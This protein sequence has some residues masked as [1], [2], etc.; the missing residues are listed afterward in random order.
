MNVD[1]PFCP[2]LH[3][4]YEPILTEPPIGD[5]EDGMILYGIEFDAVDPTPGALHGVVWVSFKG[6]TL[7]LG[8]L[9]H[10]RPGSM[11]SHALLSPDAPMEYTKTAVVKVGRG[12]FTLPPGTGFTVWAPKGQIAR[13]ILC[14]A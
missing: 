7:P 10:A 2:P 3:P 9:E 1:N 5:E 6:T 8:L 13:A 14:W 12:Q 11:Y 4:E